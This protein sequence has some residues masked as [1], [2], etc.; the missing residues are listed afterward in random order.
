[1]GNVVHAIHKCNTGHAPIIPK[2]F[3]TLLNHGVIKNP[4]VTN[5]K[6]FIDAAKYFMPDIINAKHI[7]SMYTVRTVLPNVDKTDER[8]T[9]VYRVNDKIIN[10]FSG[11]IGNSVQAAID[12]LEIVEKMRTDQKR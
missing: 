2:A 10:V 6:K 7:G 3:R 12:T 1:M 8:P 11:K 9:F 4:P 5:F